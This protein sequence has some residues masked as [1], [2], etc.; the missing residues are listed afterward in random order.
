MCGTTQGVVEQLLKT[1]F[2]I[3]KDYLSFLKIIIFGLKE[4]NK[5]KMSINVLSLFVGIS[6]GRIALERAGI[7]TNNYY[8][9]EIC[10]APV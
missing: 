8:T 3:T 10:V 4:R 6:S 1:M 7:P 5:L 2:G 9:F